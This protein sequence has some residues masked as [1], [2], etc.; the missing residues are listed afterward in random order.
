MMAFNCDLLTWLLPCF[1]W[2]SAVLEKCLLGSADTVVSVYGERSPQKSP[3]AGRLVVY[4]KVCSE[5][6]SPNLGEKPP[7]LW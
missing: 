5:G 3:A 6:F 7:E 2:L 4:W 1:Q